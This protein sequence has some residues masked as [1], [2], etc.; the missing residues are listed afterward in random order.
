MSE[1]LRF[2]GKIMSATISPEPDQWFVSIMCVADFSKNAETAYVIG[3]DFGVT[4]L[5]SKNW[6]SEVVEEAHGSHE[7]HELFI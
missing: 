7:M 5:A 6:R 3:V 2:S 4:T 1:E